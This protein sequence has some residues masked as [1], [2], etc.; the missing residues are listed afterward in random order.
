[1]KPTKCGKAT[2]DDLLERI[3]D[4][5]VVVNLD[6]VIG[7]ANI[8][9][10]GISL[11][12]AI[13]A[14]ETMIDYGMMNAWDERIRAEERLTCKKPSLDQGESVVFETRGSWLYSDGIYQAWRPVNILLSNRRL[15][16]FTKH[17]VRVAWEAWLRD[18]AEARVCEKASQLGGREIVMEV[19][20]GDG[21]EL[22][23]RSARLDRL[24][25]DLQT[26]GW[27]AD[28]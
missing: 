18:I 23:L 24:M 20:V 6:L 5:G 14:I 7:I 9:L 25:D 12:A 15:I 27:G 17:P 28:Q 10:I 2:L 1:M 11:R 13:A 4:K 3:L 26:T 16:L 21:R 8:P 22:L 19:R